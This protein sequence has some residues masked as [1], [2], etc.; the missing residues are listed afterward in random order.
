M[1]SSA[2]LSATSFQTA[3]RTPN[4]NTKH[5]ENPKVW[6]IAINSTTNMNT[7][8]PLASYRAIFDSAENLLHKEHI[9]K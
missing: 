9:L 3:Q 6:F 2:V 4:L 8:L 1:A 5:S 7:R